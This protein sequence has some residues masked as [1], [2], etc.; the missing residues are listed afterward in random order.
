[1][2]AC[3]KVVVNAVFCAPNGI[4]SMDMAE[5]RWSVVD[6]QLLLT[7]VE[8]GTMV[9]LFDLQGNRL[10]QGRSNGTDI[11]IPLGRE[12]LVILRIGGKAVRIA[13]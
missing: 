9:S 8:T 5:W 2:P 6:N 7:Q 11:T 1:M 10:W 4:K 13:R 3:R 12:P